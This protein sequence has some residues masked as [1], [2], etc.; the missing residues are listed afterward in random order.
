MQ[1][2]DKQTVIVTDGGGGMRGALCCP[3]D[4]KSPYRDGVVALKRERKPE[5]RQLTR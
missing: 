5:F 1:R 2:F 4:N 3:F